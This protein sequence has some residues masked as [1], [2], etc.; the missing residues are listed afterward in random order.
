MSDAP[1]PLQIEHVERPPLPWRNDG[2]TEC[3]LTAGNHPTITREALVAKVK[4]EGKTRAFYTTCQTCLETTQRHP[5]WEE[6][7]V[8]RYQRELT[9]WRRDE[10][11]E[12]A[13]RELKAIAMLIAA[14]RE[15]FERTLAALDEAT[16]LAE[17][18]RKRRAR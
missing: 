2:L 5:T 9:L 14:H 11:Y 12:R 18:R 13:R 17:H 8:G 6:D 16:D 7:P 3:G 1:P 4:H 10:K 15:E